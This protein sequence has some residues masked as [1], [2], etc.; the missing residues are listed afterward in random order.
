MVVPSGSILTSTIVG[1]DTYTASNGAMTHPTYTFTLTGPTSTIWNDPAAYPTEDPFNKC[2]GY[3]RMPVFRPTIKYW[4]TGTPNTECLRTCT[5]INPLGV[6]MTSNATST[7]VATTTTIPS[8]TSSSSSVDGST[9]TTSSTHIKSDS[10]TAGKVPS[11]SSTSTT[12]TASTTSKSTSTST[13]P[14]ST[15]SPANDPG[16][17]S[18]YP[19]SL[20]I[21]AR[22]ELAPQTTSFVSGSM[23]HY[24]VDE[25]DGFT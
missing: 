1:M 8:V 17:P 10:E 11:S 9:S 13:S 5:S 2:C 14:T 23:I 12:S 22:Q 15:S 25:E 3:C 18:Q 4:P 24:S 16:I 19:D 6:T 7:A 20:L 21:T